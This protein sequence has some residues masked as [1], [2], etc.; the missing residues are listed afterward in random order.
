MDKRLARYQWA[1][2]LVLSSVH[3]TVDMLGN[4]LPSILPELRSEFVLSLSAAS[5]PMIALTLTANGGQLATGHLRSGQTRPLFLHVGLALGI[6]ICLFAALPKSSLG[7]PAMILLAAITGFGIAVVHPEGLRG[8]HTLTAVPPAISTAVFMTGGFLGFAGGGAISATLVSR[9]GLPGLYPMLLFPLCGIALVI[10]LKIRL[11]VEP[12]PGR[13]DNPAHARHSRPPFR[14]VLIMAMPAAVSTTFIAWL[15]PTRLVSELG[16]DLKFGGFS[17]TMFGLGGALGSSIL[18]AVAHRKGE[19]LCSTVAYLFAGPLALAYVLL[20]NHSG[21]MWIVFATGFFAFAGYILLITL[22]RY[23]AGAGLGARMGWMV[24]GTWF[25]ATILFL[26]LLPAIERFG[27]HLIL[28]Y[29][30]LGYLLSGLFGIYLLLKI[31]S[32]HFQNQV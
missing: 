15:L 12:T 10:L 22:A 17:A 18:A 3:F 7:V 19:L 8:I 27:T 13:A 14:L 5:L 20:M 2:L 26:P 31:R 16:F 4:M 32:G 28:Q 30:P 23:V 11:A 9:F 1:Q 21:A 29:A 6:F 25:F 24:G